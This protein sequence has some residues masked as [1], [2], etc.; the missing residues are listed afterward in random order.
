MLRALKPKSIGPAII[1]M[2]QPTLALPGLTRGAAGLRNRR[3]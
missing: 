3:M 2:T 1:E